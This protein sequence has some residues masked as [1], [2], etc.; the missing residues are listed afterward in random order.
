MASE[1]NPFIFYIF[2]FYCLC[3]YGLCAWTRPKSW[4]PHSK[5]YGISV[6][7]TEEVVGF[8]ISQSSLHLKINSHFWWK[9][10]KTLYSCL[11]WRRTILFPFHWATGQGTARILDIM[12]TALSF[13]YGPSPPKELS[14]TGEHKSLSITIDIS[15]VPGVDLELGWHSLGKKNEKDALPS[16]QKS[17]QCILVFYFSRFG[18]NFSFLVTKNF[19]MKISF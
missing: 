7:L 4:V 19:W 14:N 13:L 17:S 8:C 18:I 1:R 9:K 15:M 2:T 3:F 5:S 11:L 12:F 6:Y 16:F 10:R